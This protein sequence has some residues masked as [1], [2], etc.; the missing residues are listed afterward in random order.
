M[1]EVDFTT[2]NKAKKSLE[3]DNVRP[4]TVLSHSHAQYTPCNDLAIAGLLCFAEAA[5][6]PSLICL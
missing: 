5:C 2:V 3:E 1:E 4:S 6:T